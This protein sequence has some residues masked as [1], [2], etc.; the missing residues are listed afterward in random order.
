MRTVGVLKSAALATA[1]ALAAVPAWATTVIAA[2]WNMDETFGTTMTDSSGNGNDG[3]TYNVG[4]SGS[5]Y[6]FDGSTSMVVV[7][8]SPT[9]NPGTSNFS[10]SVQI[11]TDR[12]PPS[13]TDYD[14][15][16]KGLADAIGGEYKIE[17][18]N[19]NGIGEA[20]CR[21]K[22]AAGHIGAIGGT[23]D[24]SDGALHTL[25]CSKLG[26]RVT[27]KVDGLALR[28]KYVSLGSIS[29]TADLM[30]GARTTTVTDV[31]NDWY[32]GTM[33]SAKVTVG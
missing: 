8:D 15:L 29:N 28:K 9:L 22:D 33:R 21:I 30:I 24:V 5:G 16:R 11:Q 4:T 3:T 7:P 6:I 13:G 23:T 31:T 27:L 32:S 12:I 19:N 2:Q 26:N 17:I 25:T 18:I 10:Y 14:V 1:L 20:Y